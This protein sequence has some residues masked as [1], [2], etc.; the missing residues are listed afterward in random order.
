VYV[1]GGY[2]DPL[3]SELDAFFLGGGLTWNDDNLKY[4]LG[5]VPSGAF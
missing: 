5:S 3:E 2:D 4:L 1:W